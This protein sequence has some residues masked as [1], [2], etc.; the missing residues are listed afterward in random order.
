M[1]PY[2]AKHS[3]LLSVCKPV[4]ITLKYTLA[5]TQNYI[6]ARI[7]ALNKSVA[8][9]CNDDVPS[10]AY[11]AEQNCRIRWELRNGMCA[12]RNCILA[13]GGVERCI[14]IPV[15][16]GQPKGQGRDRSIQMSRCIALMK[17]RRGSQE[18][19]MLSLLCMLFL[20]MIRKG[21]VKRY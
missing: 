3:R 14:L 4:L 10:S 15:M 11:V 7:Y 20:G 9:A 6:L 13:E 2:S 21:Q 8:H 1:P 19:G 5:R 18:S 16:K 17:T 12:G